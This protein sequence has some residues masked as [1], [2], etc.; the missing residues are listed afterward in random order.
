MTKEQELQIE[1]IM[2]ED[3][4]RLNDML[5]TPQVYEF[6][7]TKAHTHTLHTYIYT[8]LHIRHRVLAPAILSL[9]KEPAS[10]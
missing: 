3:M 8:Y 7:T 5:L 4:Q 10:A 9:H 2:N 6:A 1:Q